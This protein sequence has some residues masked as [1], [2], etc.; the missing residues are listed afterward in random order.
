MATIKIDKREYQVM[1]RILEMKWPSFVKDGERIRHNQ[2][3]FERH[4]FEDYYSIDF[5][6]ENESLSFSMNHELTLFHGSQMCSKNKNFKNEEFVCYEDHCS[7]EKEVK[8]MVYL[9]GKTGVLFTRTFYKEDTLE[10]VLADWGKLPIEIKV[11]LC[12][13]GAVK[14]TWCENCYIW[15]MEHPTDPYCAIC[16]ENEGVYIKTE[17]GHYF[18]LDC[19]WRIDSTDSGKRKCPICRERGGYSSTKF[20]NRKD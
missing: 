12:G 19:Y 7:C 14:D 13:K 11:C 8:Y 4:C 9:T 3:Q 5:G 20:R 1:M 15:R 17:C 16:L 6:G 10:Q 18:H 2:K